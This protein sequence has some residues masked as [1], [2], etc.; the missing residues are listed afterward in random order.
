MF[1]LGRPRQAPRRWGHAARTR[2]L[3]GGIG[4]DAATFTVWLQVSSDASAV[5]RAPAQ[6]LQ[7][8][9]K[10]GLEFWPSLHC[11]LK[12][13]LAQRQSSQMPGGWSGPDTQSWSHGSANSAH[14]SS[15]H[16]PGLPLST[17][18]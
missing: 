7:S 10:E 2:R 17:L 5:S 12:Y 18:G 13:I 14:C 9:E 4:V 11:P 15:Q 16:K 1:Y 6:T 8:R 3:K